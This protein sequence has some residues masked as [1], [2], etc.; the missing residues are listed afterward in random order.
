[1]RILEKSVQKA[2]AKYYGSL[3]FS[4]KR[5][6]KTPVGIIDFLLYKDMGRKSYSKVMVEV[7][8]AKSIKHAVGQLYSYKHYHP[9][10]T[11]MRV[12]YF[13]RN[14]R[15][16][17]IDSSFLTIEDIKF[18]CVHTFLPLET[19]LSYQR[20]E[21]CATSENFNKTNNKDEYD[22]SSHSQLILDG[23]SDRLSDSVYNMKELEDIQHIHW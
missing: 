11:D 7:K 21:R 12:A 3:G 2:L 6:V 5:E 13:T 15:Y 8:E 14:G 9:D 1:M 10:V 19:I 16:S 18:D 17:A 23:D 4:V 22:N 20:I